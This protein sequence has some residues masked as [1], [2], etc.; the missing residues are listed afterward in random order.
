MLP[1][2][3]QFESK[4]DISF[5]NKALLKEAF[6]HRSYLNENRGSVRR[7]NERLEFLGEAV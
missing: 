3:E 5:N 6:T 4:I 2:F 7:H 1:K